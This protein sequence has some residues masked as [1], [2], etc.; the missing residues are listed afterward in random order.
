MSPATY[1]FVAALLSAANIA[2]WTLNVFM[3]PGN[4]LIVLT[5]ALFAWLV[6]TDAGY[7]IS[8]WT[9]GMLAVIAAI[10]ELLEFLSGGRAAAK[11][12]AARRSVVLAT[13]GAMAGSLC[14]T[15]VGAIVPIVGSILGA[16]VGGA[17]GAAAGAYVGEHTLGRSHR[18][19]SQVAR[20]AFRGRLWGTAAKLAAGIVMLVIQTFDAFT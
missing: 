9:V 16:I 18:R 13:A 8:W 3:L 10:G 19:K 15:S 7:G 14:G 20:A 1:Y 2:C 17:L 11:Q 4:W 5:T 6:R 12:Q